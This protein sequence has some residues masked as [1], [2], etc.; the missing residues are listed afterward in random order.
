MTSVKLCDV[1]YSNYECEMTNVK[2]TSVPQAL[3]FNTEY[4][5]GRYL[6]LK[7]RNEIFEQSLNFKY[8]FGGYS[9]LNIKYQSG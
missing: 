1:E 8:Q 4:Q 9:I 5:S 7:H 3:I 2:P 6:N